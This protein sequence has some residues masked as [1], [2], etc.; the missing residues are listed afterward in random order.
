MFCPKC[1]S[2]NRENLNFCG[3]CGAALDN[4]AP[5]ADKSVH[6]P[7]KK[8]KAPETGKTADKIKSESQ[9][10]ITKYL[11]ARHGKK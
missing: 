6:N 5:T 2:E 3:K 11:G 10:W 4:A 9:K 7:P 8:A 1:G